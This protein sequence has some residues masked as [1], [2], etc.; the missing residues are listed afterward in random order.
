[1]AR[2][3]HHRLAGIRA[4]RREVD[5]VGD[6]RWRGLVDVVRGLGDDGVISAQ[7]RFDGVLPAAGDQLTL[8]GSRSPRVDRLAWST[9]AIAVRYGADRV[10]QG[11]VLDSDNARSER[12]V[13][14]RRTH[15]EV[16]E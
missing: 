13:T 8:L 7:L 1:M 16:Q 5:E 12:R 2:E 10:M 4:E 3:V 14:W 15:P 9:A 11:D 6:T